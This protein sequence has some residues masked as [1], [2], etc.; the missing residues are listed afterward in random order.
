MGLA[1]STGAMAD[2]ASTQASEDQIKAQYKAD[3]ETCKSMS[4]NAKDICIAQAKGR[5]E[6]A[7]AELDASRKNTEKARHNVLV[8]KAEAEYEVAKERCDDRAGNDKDVCLKDA[9]AA[10]VTAKAD[11]KA[12]LKTSKAMNNAN[13][14]SVEA[15]EK[16]HA[17]AADVRKEGMEDKQDATY[18]AAKERCDALAGN[19]KDVCIND[20]KMRHGKL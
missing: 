7:E 15:H 20:A 13:D 6:I 14:K 2:T 11:A 12:Q 10:L 1:F 8:T 3:K 5:E 4:G 16:A 19:A 9:K 17:K 18:A